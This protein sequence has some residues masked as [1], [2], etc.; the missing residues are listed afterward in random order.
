MPN[1]AQNTA[2]QKAAAK[3]KDA[4]NIIH[5]CMGDYIEVVKYK[6]DAGYIPVSLLNN[7]I[8]SAEKAIS[9]A[10]S[11]NYKGELLGNA[12]KLKDVP[13]K[14]LKEWPIKED[15]LILPIIGA[16]ELNSNIINFL[17]NTIHKIWE[18]LIVTEGQIKACAVAGQ[19]Y[20][21]DMKAVDAYC[22]GFLKTSSNANAK[23]TQ[24]P[25]KYLPKTITG[26]TEGKYVQFYPTLIKH[27][28]G[29]HSVEV[30]EH[31][32]DDKTNVAIEY[33]ESGP[34]YA[35][36]KTRM[37]GV[38]KR[39]TKENLTC[40]PKYPNLYCSGEIDTDKLTQLAAFFSLVFN[41]DIAG[42]GKE[43][44][45]VVSDATWDYAG[46]L[47]AKYGDDTWLSGQGQLD[48][49][50][51][52]NKMVEDKELMEKSKI[53]GD[54]KQL[55]ICRDKHHELEE[56]LG[57]GSTSKASDKA[58]KS[59]VANAN[60]ALVLCEKN[61]W[62]TGNLGKFKNTFASMGDWGTSD[63]IGNTIHNILIN[64]L[65]QLGTYGNCNMD[66]NLADVN[67]GA[68]SYC[69]GTL[70][71]TSTVLEGGGSQPLHKVAPNQ[72]KSIIIDENPEGG[73]DI[74]IP[75]DKGF[76]KQELADYLDEKF[77][78]DCKSEGYGSWKAGTVCNVHIDSHDK[79]RLLA[80]FLS[81]LKGGSEE[82]GT[83]CV[84]I[85]MGEAWKAAEKQAEKGSMAFSQSPVM[86]TAKDWIDKC[87]K[88]YGI[89]PPGL[90]PEQK[91]ILEMLG[92]DKIYA[93]CDLSTEELVPNM[94]ILN[95]CEG[96]RVNPQA[97]I[98]A[99][100]SHA[101]YLQHF[102][103]QT[104]DKLA[105]V[106][107]NPLGEGKYLVEVQ[108]IDMRDPALTKDVTDRLKLMNYT[109]KGDSCQKEIG[110]ND[111]RWL[112]MFLSSL[113]QAYKL[114]HSQIP[115]AVNLA[116][117]KINQIPND[118]NAYKNKVYPWTEEDWN[119]ELVKKP[120]EA[121][122]EKKGVVI[123]SI[124][125]EGY[126]EITP[127]YLYS[128]PES[129]TPPWEIGGCISNLKA[130]PTKIKAGYCAGIMK[131]AVGSKKNVFNLG[132]ISGKL[133]S[134]ESTQ[135]V[136][137]SGNIVFDSKY[138]SLYIT[139]PDGLAKIKPVTDTLIGHFGFKWN[140]GNTWEKITTPI[141]AARVAYFFSHLH[142]IEKLPEDCWQKAVE[143]ATAQATPPIYKMPVYPVDVSDWMKDVCQEEKP[144]YALSAMSKTFQAELTKDICELKE[145]GATIT[146]V[147]DW[148][149]ST[150]P[151]ITFG[152][153][154]KAII[155][156]MYDACE[157]EAPKIEIA[158]DFLWGP[159]WTHSMPGAGELW[160]VPEEDIKQLLKEGVGAADIIKM[161]GE[162]KY[163]QA[164]G[165]GI[166]SY[167]AAKEIVE[168]IQ[169]ELLETKP[170]IDQL[171]DES[172][173]AW[174]ELSK[175][176]NSQPDLVNKSHKADAYKKL[177]KLAKDLL[178]A[179]MNTE[180]LKAYKTGKTY[181]QLLK[182]VQQSFKGAFPKLT[183]LMVKLQ[184]DI[185]KKNKIRKGELPAEPG[186]KVAHTYEELSEEE[187]ESVNDAI[188]ESLEG[189][190]QG[191]AG[192]VNSEKLAKEAGIENEPSLWAAVNAMAEEMWPGGMKFYNDLKPE[193]KKLVDTAI[194]E[195]AAEGK[196]KNLIG[197]ELIE[198][199][200]V[201]IT[202]DMDVKIGKEVEAYQK[203]METAGVEI[204]VEEHI[205]SQEEI[206]T[207]EDMMKSV[208]QMGWT[209]QALIEFFAGK[210]SE[211][212]LKKTANKLYKL[213]RPD[214]VRGGMTIE[215]AS[216]ELVNHLKSIAGMMLQQGKS[217]ADTAWYISTN[218]ALDKASVRGMVKKVAEK[219]L[220]QVEAAVK[221]MQLIATGDYI[222]GC[223]VEEPMDQ[224]TAQNISYCQ[225][226]LEKKATLNE[227]GSE[228]YHKMAT[229]IVDVN[230]TS[231]IAKWMV[232][233]NYSEKAM[234]GNW[235][236]RLDGVL[237]TLIEMGFSCEQVLNS[238]AVNCHLEGKDGM[239][240]PILE[241]DRVRKAALFLSS[242]DNVSKLDAACI[243]YAL[244]YA[245][246]SAKKKNETS[247]PWTVN[248]YPKEVEDWNTIV[249]SKLLA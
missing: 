204:P 72:Y 215:E 162:G 26:Q 86:N 10:E 60:V 53:Y 77:G 148:F 128:L 34:G 218:Y 179:F 12:K 234:A 193:A 13:M 16:K 182:K 66:K 84:P 181:D 83:E 188:K 90:T 197:D 52:H 157:A 58:V 68:L 244:K 96:V 214:V 174:E 55:A 238:A 29:A 155:Q 246:E 100:L 115:K 200:N 208:I 149:S 7:V 64:Q 164:S 183:P 21:D 142:N 145:D 54:L 170:D 216:T 33:H 146:Q 44:V 210:M 105:D 229:Q 196:N 206:E 173:E 248:V 212:K 220:S 79:I 70:K 213:Y 81:N 132:N 51:M 6:K 180:L 97:N 87:Y 209:P 124:S 121:A 205:P 30:S 108:N 217:I 24:V 237:D 152:A 199:F 76:W 71:G 201:Y 222:G 1:T 23:V 19:I 95:Y 93:G 27:Q 137:G 154:A 245:A 144:G 88:Q 75:I 249:C 39:L 114:E 9:A 103:H 219:P 89:T 113:H 235:K 101:G 147:F 46:E 184:L 172:Q 163:W 41:A 150:H 112:A 56:A 37:Q 59:I 211:D 106:F 40:F 99:H 242:V 61:N 136:A 73:Y 69:E 49:H 102:F 109:C 194:T 20:P 2:Q 168:N 187:K 36:S 3:I 126:P 48:W 131:Q 165:M 45:P 135:F 192:M 65:S 239:A 28:L 91:I 236:D 198:Q 129:G 104:T 153:N 195:K 224:L 11:I 247:Q 232:D 85:A 191:N 225:G 123:Y 17:A 80:I 110:E 122:K 43:T 228:V 119:K 140:G 159:A 207:Y 167:N 5:Q 32:G 78:F 47:V 107:I 178:H 241:Q 74:H 203:L 226:V 38:Q 190:G 169:N 223:Q 175:K 138:N 166:I 98:S 22:S 177:P 117:E 57:L 116:I 160:T 185:E 158:E 31:G 63:A 141:M 94:G 92:V 176:Y 111:I 15:N 134:K 240:M 125:E 156:E 143:Y 189:V 202:G 18:D 62:S 151:D 227:A 25:L 243:P 120:S 139:L 35:N 4:H 127:G 161:L 14:L 186:E 82:I 50:N 130:G 233:L 171:I 42:L 133:S 230:S 118:K 221:A 231:E 8:D 67:A